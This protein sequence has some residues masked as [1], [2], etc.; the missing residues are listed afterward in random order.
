MSSIQNLLV[1]ATAQL[2]EASDSAMLDAEVLLAFVLEKPRSHLRAWPEK[3]VNPPHA[4]LFASLI[5]HR[6]QGIPVAYITSRREFWSR[7]FYITPEVLIPRPDTELLVE[8]S[9]GLIAR[10]TINRIVDLG[11]GSGIIA[12]TLAAE[13]PQLNVIATDA[14]LSAL[15]IARCN[16]KS[17][18]IDNI[19]FIQSDWFTDVPDQKFH[20]VISNPPYIDE[21][22]SHL[23]QGDVRFEPLSALVATQHGLGDI[24]AITQQTRQR[25]E[26][27]GHLLIEHGYNQQQQVQDIFKKL[28]YTEIKTYPDLSGNPRVTYGQWRG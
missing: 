9:L 8:L 3:T 14:H 2:V 12:I 6:Q 22:D 25:L 24:L 23:Q 21:N 16:A 10:D 15:N 20:L 28:G 26:E 18:Q 11:T 5:K 17:H 19:Q 1:E 4:Q 27:N 7:D 13:C